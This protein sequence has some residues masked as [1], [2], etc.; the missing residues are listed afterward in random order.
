M[1]EY[2]ESVKGEFVFKLWTQAPLSELEGESAESVA[3]SHGRVTNGV[4]DPLW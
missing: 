2:G 1:D 3:I 4:T